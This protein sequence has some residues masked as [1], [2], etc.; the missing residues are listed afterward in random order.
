MVTYE[1]DLDQARRHFARA[2]AGVDDVIAGG[3][4]IRIGSARYR[5]APVCHITDYGDDGVELLLRYWV[6]RPYR[7]QTARSAV[8]EAVW[9]EMEELDIEFAYPHR[10]HIFDQTSGSVHVDLGE[11]DDTLS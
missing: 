11:E 10:H 1:G 4:P 7:L 6:K 9:T 2:A 5:A 8:L 3:P